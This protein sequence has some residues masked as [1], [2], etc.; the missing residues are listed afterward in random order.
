MYAWLNGPGQV[1]RDPLPNSTN[2]LAAYDKAGRLVRARPSKDK[3]ES[4]QGKDEEADAENSKD[5]DAVEA[6]ST[7]ESDAE[8]LAKHAQRQA[9]ESRSDESLPPETMDD[10]RPYPQ[11]TQFMSQPV[12]SVELRDEIFRRVK[13]EGL[14]VRTV[15][16]QLGVAI[17]RV[18]AVVRLKALEEEWKKQGKKLATPYQSALLSMLP[19]TPFNPSRP[20]S[21]PHEPI[22]DLPVHPL[23]RPQLFLPVA[24]SRAF[25][26]TD[27]AHAFSSPGASSTNTNS[28]NTSTSST[29]AFLPAHLRIPH[30]DL[31]EAEQLRLSGLPNRDV[32]AQMAAAKAARE[33]GAREREA[34][35]EAAAAAARKVVPGRRWDF[36]FEDVQVE[37]VG[38]DGLGRG[39][40]GWRYGAPHD[41]RKRGVVKI[42]TRVA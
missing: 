10:L 41:D 15:S 11:N 28:H 23:T 29:G 17:E 26:R 38:R 31:V 39:G 27:A 3:D 34:R 14:D 13:E 22:N 6:S 37:S 18:G 35:R 12:L 24:E 9:K 42:P 33:A 16:V 4:D 2:Y 30:P 21:N 40:V 1:F 7:E 5:P 36:R 20:A 19:T 25:T 8:R 32:D